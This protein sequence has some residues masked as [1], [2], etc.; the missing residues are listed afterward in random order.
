MRTE[1]GRRVKGG[2][3]REESGR[4]MREEDEK[5]RH[6]ED[7]RVECGTIATYEKGREREEGRG[8]ESGGWHYSNL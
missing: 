6:I 2:R 1:E 4:R 8:C 5:G 3:Q 7:V